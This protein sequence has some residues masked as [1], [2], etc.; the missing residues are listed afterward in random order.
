[1]AKTSSRMGA[2][3]ARVL[4]RRTGAEALTAATTTEK[5]PAFRRGHGLN[6]AGYKVTT[7]RFTL[8]H[9]RWLREQAVSRSLDSGARADASEI[10]RE[11]VAAA[12]RKE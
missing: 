8:E 5:A 9:W 11:L 1:M 6:Q 2:A 10:V 12:M 4:H 7:I 3:G